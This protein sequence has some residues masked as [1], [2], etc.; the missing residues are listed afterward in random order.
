[1]SLLHHQIIFIAFHLL[2]T[3]TCI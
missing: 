1:M 2:H 3:R